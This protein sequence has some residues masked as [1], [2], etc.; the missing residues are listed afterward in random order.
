LDGALKGGR[1]ISEVDNNLIMKILIFGTLYEPDLGPSAPLFTTLSKEFAKSGHKVTVIV[2]VPHYPSGR[3]SRAFRGRFFWRTLEGGVN[4]IRVGLPSVNR[5]KLPLRLL[6]FICYQVGAAWAIMGQQ[7]DIVLAGSP[8]ISGW[9][10]FA[11]SVVIRRKPAVYSV[12]DLYPSIGITLGIFRNKAV[13]AV[14]S[15]LEKFCL[16]HAAVVQ[17]I[18][19]SF[20]PGLRELGVPDS[21]IALIYNWVDT[22]FIRPLP[23]SNAFSK[24]YRLED[25]FVILYAGN[26][27]PSQ[28]LENILVAAE[29]LREEKDILFI[30]VGDGLTKRSLMLEAEKRSLNNV[31]F[32]PFQPRERLPEIMASGNVSLVP[33]RKG[34][35]KGSL[36]SKLSTVLASGRPVL[37]CVEENSEMWRL[38]KGAN[39]G[40]GIPP[41]DADE[42]CKGILTLKGN[43][44]L[45]EQMGRCGRV[46]AEQ[47]LSP[48]IAKKKFEEIF[49]IAIQRNLRN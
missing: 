42:L 15:A 19:E 44:R 47:N 33:L 6:Q 12:Q 10:P 40:I 48:N 20:K 24:E 30:L 49:S 45:C 29:E 27:G 4:V 34:V 37:A 23:R 5:K 7:Y 36:P 21:K 1:S 8:S 13:I 14:V 43:E 35:E 11:L 2:P 25:R 31:L 3:V 26:I 38:V 9:L 28:G 16:K 32:L 39:G 46:W 17:I 22:E 41:E 18:S